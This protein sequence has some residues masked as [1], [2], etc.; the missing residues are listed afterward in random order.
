MNNNLFRRL[1][2]AQVAACTCMTKTPDIEYHDELCH[3]RLFRECQY[4]F[5]SIER[6]NNSLPLYSETSDIL[7]RIAENNAEVLSDQERGHLMD[8]AHLLR[9]LQKNQPLSVKDNTPTTTAAVELCPIGM[10]D[11]PQFCSAGTCA[12]CRLIRFGNPV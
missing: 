5:M 7:E 4:E 3:F 2:Q 10:D 11:R 6:E 8:A 12:K 9:V 1:S